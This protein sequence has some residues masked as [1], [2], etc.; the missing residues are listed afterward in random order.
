MDA[1]LDPGVESVLT[2]SRALGF[3]GPG[4]IGPQAA[5]AAAFAEAVL[6]AS[7]Q[8]LAHCVAMVSQHFASR[9]IFS[10]RRLAEHIKRG[11]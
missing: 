5:H 8:H 9:C 4:D 2:R 3:L 11:Q 7:A 6:S 1:P 10:W